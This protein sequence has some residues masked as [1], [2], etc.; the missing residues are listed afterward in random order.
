MPDGPALAMMLLAGLLLF[1]VAHAVGGWY[2]VA[3]ALAG[4][5]LGA[6][7]LAVWTLLES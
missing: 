6:L 3:M 2:G 1:A 4:I 7:A 5:S